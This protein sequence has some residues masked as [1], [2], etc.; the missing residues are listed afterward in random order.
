MSRVRVFASVVTL[1]ITSMACAQGAGRP[2]GGPPGGGLGSGP[3]PSPDAVV[4]RFM[5]GD[6]NADGK[7][8]KDELPAPFVER[9]FDAADANKDG[10]I[11]RDELTKYMKAQSEGRGRGGAGEGRGEGGPQEGRGEGREGRA[12]RGGSFEGGMKQAG[13]GFKGLEKSTFTAESMNADLEAVSLIQ[14]GMASS[15]GLIGQVKMSDAAKKKF[16]TDEAA[17]RAELR[18]QL[19]A[20]L[21][22]AIVLEEAILAGKSADAK[23]AYERLHKAEEAGHELFQAEEKD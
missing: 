6:K 10:S 23:A 16:G 8:T 22:E 11:D 2:A 21:K 4:D 15:K 5:Q 17:F 13:R 14:A 20:A 1:L 18:K 3:A 12:P 19:F 7:L 9:A